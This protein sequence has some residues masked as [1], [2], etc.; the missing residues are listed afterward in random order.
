MTNEQLVAK[1]ERDFETMVPLEATI[2]GRAVVIPPKVFSTGSIGYHFT[3]KVMIGGRLTQVNLLFT[4]VGTKPIDENNPKEVAA[5]AK[6]EKKAKPAAP[7]AKT[8]KSLREKMEEM[9]EEEAL[10]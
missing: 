3:D 2:D 1:N 8:G 6:A 10:A 9:K 5:R 7:P 4:L